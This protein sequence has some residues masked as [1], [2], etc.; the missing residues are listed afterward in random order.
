M[1]RLAAVPTEPPVWC[2]VGGLSPAVK[3]PL[4]EACIERGG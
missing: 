4:R 1:S 2:L 3:R